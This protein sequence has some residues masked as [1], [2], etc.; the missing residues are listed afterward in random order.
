MQHKGGGNIT[1]AGAVSF[2]TSFVGR[3]AGVLRVY[4]AVSRACKV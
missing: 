2:Y 1:G 4:G 3:A